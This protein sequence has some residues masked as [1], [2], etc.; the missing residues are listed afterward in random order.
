ME[1]KAPPPRSDEEIELLLEQRLEGE[2]LALPVG[3]ADRVRGACP[4]APWEA[5]QRRH[6]KVPAFVLG[7]L[8][9]SAFVLGLAPLLRLGPESAMRVWAQ[10][11]AV[12][13][14]RPAFVAVETAPLAAKAASRAL[15]SPGTLPLLAVSAA[16]GLGLLGLALVPVLRRRRAGDAAAR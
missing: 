12:S 15:A 13:V 6:W 7:L 2:E 10:L 11:I 9:G 5:R 4:F 14:I 8:S 3:F 1:Q 16:L